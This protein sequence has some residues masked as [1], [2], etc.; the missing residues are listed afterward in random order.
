M[1]RQTDAQIP[2]L[3]VRHARRILASSILKRVARERGYRSITIK[4]E[5]KRLGFAD[6]QCLVPGLLIP[7][8]NVYGEIATYQWRPDAPR[9][10]NG[11][12]TKYETPFRTTMVLDVH[13]FARPQLGD[14]TLPL[15]VTEGVRKGGAAVSRGLCCIALLGVEFPQDECIRR[16]N[17]S[18]GL[19][20]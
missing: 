14:P 4:A 11:K 13:P 17:D 2:R 18:P 12:A 9:V 1:T 19:G 10:K 16:H 8:W 7:I 6:S 3:L 5:L 15:W 20:G